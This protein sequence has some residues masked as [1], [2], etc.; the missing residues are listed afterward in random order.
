MS[1]IE[2][3][4]LAVRFGEVQALKGVSLGVARGEF[5]ALVGPNGSGKTTLLRAMHGMLR[6]RGTISLGAD[7]GRQAMVFQ[8]PFVM[9]LSVRNNLRLALWLAK[10]PRASWDE[11][12]AA[13]LQRVALQGLEQRPARALSGGQQ[14][15]LALARAWAVQPALLFLDEP[16]ASLD[17]T[18]KREVEA[19]LAGFAADGMTLVM[20]THNLGQA[21]RL[22][23]RVVY[24][25]DG[26]VHA[27]LPTAQFFNGRLQGR[28]Q[29]FLK[30]EMAWTIE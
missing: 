24:L 1:L 23:S 26:E 10:V 4:D 7:V 3:K 29:Q 28:A 6:H 25:E 15:R 13:A 5:V 8:R 30:G 9:R 2:V 14:Q 27:D 12:V 11:R 16:T 18:A 21:K 20:S 19:L 22:A 17:P